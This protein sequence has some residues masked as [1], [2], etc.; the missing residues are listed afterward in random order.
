M[1][2]R[3]ETSGTAWSGARGSSHLSRMW[4]APSLK[5]R[6]SPI[7][8]AV[9]L[10]LRVIGRLVSEMTVAR[11]QPNE[12][13]IGGGQAAIRAVLSG[14]AGCYGPADRSDDMT[15]CV[16]EMVR[17][18]VQI[19]VV[20]PSILTDCDAVFTAKNAMSVIVVQ[21]LDLIDQKLPRSSFGPCHNVC[22]L[23]R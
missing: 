2:S 12:S 18:G 1:E 13:V 9:M 7:Q 20:W 3:H 16:I 15:R 6:D 23:R 5:L 14:P 4:S 19:Q 10:D 21:P 11:R 17:E 22:G 8:M